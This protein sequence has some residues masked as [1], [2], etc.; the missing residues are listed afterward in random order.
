MKRLVN[1]FENEKK[2]WNIRAIFTCELNSL[3]RRGNFSH[4]ELSRKSKLVDPTPKYNTQKKKRRGEKYCIKIKGD[5]QRLY[6]NFYDEFLNWRVRKKIKRM[7]ITSETVYNPTILKIKMFLLKYDLM[8]FSGSKIHTR[9][10]IFIYL[11]I[12]DYFTTKFQKLKLY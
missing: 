4:K 12:K 5:S 9:S 3:F 11:S 7:L 6:S 8:M 2:N 10:D 1:L